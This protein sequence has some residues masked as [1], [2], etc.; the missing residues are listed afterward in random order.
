MSH[1]PA[2]GDGDSRPTV[3]M[4]VTAGRRGAQGARHLA[5]QLAEAGWPARVQ[6]SRP[7]R[8]EAAVRDQRANGAS[9]ITVAGGDGTIRTAAQA[10]A[11]DEHAALAVVPTGTLN[12][13]AR[14]LGIYS[15][16]D[17]V[18]TLRA[19]HTEPLAV[20]TVGERVF[21]NTATFGLYA[22]VVRRRER[23]RRVIGRWPAALTAFLVAIARDRP[24][25]VELDIDGRRIV[26]T[27]ALVW[28]GVGYGS[29][30]VVHD[31]REQRTSPD[32]EVAILRKCG[33][34][35]LL[36]FGTRM[37]AGLARGR[38]PIRDDAIEVLHTRRFTLDAGRHG[39][40]MTLDGEATRVRGP[41]HIAVRDDALRVVTATRNVGQP[42]DALRPLRGQADRRTHRSR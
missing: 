19:G 6:R 22:D 2:A 39:V 33:R 3:L 10:L 15:L 4:N 17:A 18:A 28:V 27:T 38:R 30:P 25:A 37:L 31:A 8:L 35:A 29:F 36:G 7:D 21:L 40:G 24:I 5:E 11:G 20:G 14:R 9:V 32:L 41:A 12:N 26:R 13:F 42:E 16:E 1:A 23:W 34:L